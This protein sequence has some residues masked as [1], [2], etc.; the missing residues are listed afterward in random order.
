[1]YKINKNISIFQ[2]DTYLFDKNHISEYLIKFLSFLYRVLIEMESD[3]FEF[4]RRGD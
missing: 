1:M 3:I 4:K 2:T